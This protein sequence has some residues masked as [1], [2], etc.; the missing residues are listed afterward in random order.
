[1]KGRNSDRKPIISVSSGEKVS[2]MTFLSLI[3][4]LLK[5]IKSALLPVPRLPTTTVRSSDS[6]SARKSGVSMKALDSILSSFSAV[7]S[8]NGFVRTAEAA[9]VTLGS[10]WLIFLSKTW[11]VSGGAWRREPIFIAPFKN[12]AP[13]DG[14][15]PD[16]MAYPCYTIDLP[17]SH[18]QAPE[19]ANL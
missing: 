16:A 8:P 3:Q 1:E 2:V 17:H 19:L 4:C 12:P 5:F 11:T 6:T 14:Q 10:P 7:V 15:I 18:V 9:A 13:L